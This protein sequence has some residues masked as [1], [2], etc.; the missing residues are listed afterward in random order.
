LSAIEIAQVPENDSARAVYDRL[1]PWAKDA[2]RLVRLS[3]G[4]VPKRRLAEKGYSNRQ[5]KQM[6]HGRCQV[7]EE[8][9]PVLRLTRLGKK[10]A[11]LGATRT[12]S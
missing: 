1:P 3:G 8:S 6:V 2:T 11:L 5:L 10:V 7:L 12:Q 4:E 9:G